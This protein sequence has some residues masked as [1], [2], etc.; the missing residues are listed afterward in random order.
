MER[1]RERQRQRDREVRDPKNKRGIRENFQRLHEHTH[2]HTHTYMH[3]R[4]HTQ[5]YTYTHTYTHLVNFF[6]PSSNTLLKGVQKRS[7]VNFLF[8]KLLDGRFTILFDSQLTNCF[9]SWMNDKCYFWNVDILLQL[10]Q[11]KFEIINHFFRRSGFT[12]SVLAHSRGEIWSYSLG[13]KPL[14]RFKRSTF[15]WR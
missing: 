4:A 13:H 8:A 7:F 1:V 11:L 15:F 5:T 9:D 6:D 2:T 12:R 14:K 10:L 3:A